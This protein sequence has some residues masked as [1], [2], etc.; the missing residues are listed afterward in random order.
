M[1][2]VEKKE[3]ISNL[4]EQVTLWLANTNVWLANTNLINELTIPSKFFKREPYLK[5]LNE[6]LK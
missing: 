1:T 5:C 3:T 4:N 2:K 6:L